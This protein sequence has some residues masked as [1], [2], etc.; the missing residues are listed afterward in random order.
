MQS[1]NELFFSGVSNMFSGFFA[2]CEKNTGYSQRILESTF[3]CF[4][5]EEIDK[6]ASEKLGNTK[7]AAEPVLEEAVASDEEEVVAKP[8]KRV[9]KK[10]AVV[11]GD[12]LPRDKQT[13]LNILEL[14]NETW[15]KKT[16]AD[17]LK[18]F[19]KE[20]GL[21][22]ATTKGAM[23]KALTKYEE[24]LGQTVNTPTHKISNVRPKP[25]DAEGVWKESVSV[26]D[27]HPELVV[28]QQHGLNLIDT[29]KSFLFVISTSDTNNFW[30]IG[31]VEKDDLEGVALDEQVDVRALKKK[32]IKH[33]QEMN[34][35]VDFPDDLDV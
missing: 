26:D 33:A 1:Y 10:A 5:N 32:H 9:I 19:C 13:P 23:L 35:V 21:T 3:A 7:A 6:A 25:F 15:V 17:V 18:T 24:D 31:Y 20:R 27:N 14:T 11:G 28:I 34:L 12:A 16:K 22:S 8:K 2:Y 29:Q 30:V 4:I